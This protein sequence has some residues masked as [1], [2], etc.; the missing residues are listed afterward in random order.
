MISNNVIKKESNDLVSLSQVKKL[1][2]RHDLHLS[3]R[4]GQHF[5]IDGNI[6]QNI[7]DTADIKTDDII[8]EVGPGIGTLT[9][10]I[11]KDCDQLIAI[12]LDRRLEPVLEETTKELDNFHLFMGDALKIE[13]KELVDQEALP[14]KLISNLP[15][16]ISSTL[17]I[18]YLK[19]FD[20]LKDYTVTVQKEVA[21][22]IV[23]GPGS[24][25]YGAF[26]IKLSFL[27]T[28]DLKFNISKNVFIP[29]PNVESSLITLKRKSN[30][31]A[32]YHR[33]LFR[34]IEASF[35]QRRKK[36]VNSVSDTLGLK[37]EVLFEALSELGIKDDARAEVL[38][39]NDYKRLFGALEK[40]KRP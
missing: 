21:D 27:A 10:L 28:I 14:N 11:A 1:L 18:R 16:N 13:I 2:R 3:K 12:E 36:L 31:D 37:K 25:D 29:A 22:R 6:R 33:E 4:L 17:L 32:A 8:L 39:P 19:E 34:L 9:E 23:A 40:R 5:L 26:T 20:F 38:S 24:K 7:I 15:F 30:I 35:S